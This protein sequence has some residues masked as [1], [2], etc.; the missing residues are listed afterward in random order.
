MVVVFFSN[1]AFSCPL[2]IFIN[3]LTQKVCASSAGVDIATFAGELPYANSEEDERTVVVIAYADRNDMSF[4]VKLGRNNHTKIPKVE[5]ATPSFPTLI[6]GRYP[7]PK[8]GLA[9]LQKQ[10]WQISAEVIGYRGKEDQTG[11]STLCLRAF[12]KKKQP[13][14]AVATCSPH[15][16]ES[17]DKFNATLDEISRQATKIPKIN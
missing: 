2:P 11:P 8:K 13:G 14:I 1:L 9:A 6:E 4:R 17:T 5:L 10:G 7:M 16:S 15:F 3:T 12:S